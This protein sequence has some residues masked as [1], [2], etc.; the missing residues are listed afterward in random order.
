MLTFDFELYKDILLKEGGSERMILEELFDHCPVL[1]VIFKGPS[2]VIEYFNAQYRLLFPEREL[3]GLLLEDAIPE[4]KNTETLHQLRS[5]Y[6][7]G[8]THIAHEIR[9][10]FFSAD[11]KTYKEHYFNYTR[12]ARFNNRGEIDGV[13]SFGFDVTDMVV[14]RKNLELREKELQLLNE[15]LHEKNKDLSASYKLLELSNLQLDHAHST[16][17]G[18]NDELEH[19]VNIRSDELRLSKNEAENQRDRLMEFIVQAPVGI[20]ILGGP[21]LVFE[22]VNHAYQQHLPGRNLI[23]KPLLQAVPELSGQFID[24]LNSVYSSG[25]SFQ[26]NAMKVLLARAEGGVPEER[27]FDFTYQARTNAEGHIDGIIVCGFEVTP[28]VLSKTEIEQ[29]EKRLVALLNALPQM[30]WTKTAE[31]VVTYVNQRWYSYTGLTKNEKGVLDIFSLI[32]DDD[33][34]GAM[35]NFMK[36]V[37]VKKGGQFESRYLSADG[38]YRWHLNRMEPMLSEEG[39]IQYWIGTATEIQ[40]LKDLQQQKDDF[41]SIASHELKTPL[42]SLNLSMQLINEM[43]QHTSPVLLGNLISR[44]TKNLNKLMVLVDD[45]LNV[46]KLNQGHL[47]LNKTWFIM[48]ELVTDCCSHI[49]VGGT[50]YI[51]LEGDISV[52]VY[53]DADRIEQVILNFVN[54]AIKYAPFTKIIRIHIEQTEM[55]VKVSVIDKG[56]G[57]A[58]EKLEHLFDRY[59]RVDQSGSQYSGLGL[60]LYISAEIIERHKGIIRVDSEPGSGSTFWFSLPVYA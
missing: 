38:S 24:I 16:L 17:Q 25:R 32:H 10:P 27:F 9:I 51:E 28:L 59:Y 56:Q 54:N 34:Q 35:A 1:I 23:G 14:A 39:E 19:R 42:T 36:M 11:K 48:S 15:Q 3:L 41:V 4:V 6:T 53:A 47:H 43:K 20:C 29:N 5:V 37:S 45:L 57:I 49:A 55:G 40:A 44:A 12:M 2:L 31:G 46:S 13:L 60:G 30:A 50:N 18:M 26:G 52:K 22:V 33:K 58:A 21:D 7:T 8:K